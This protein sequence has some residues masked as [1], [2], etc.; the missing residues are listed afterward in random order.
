LFSILKIR[1]EA[2]LKPAVEIDEMRVGI[3]QERSLGQEPERDGQASGEGLDEP[4]FGVRQPEWPQV[5]YLPSFSA[6]PLQG[7]SERG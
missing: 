6:R 5:W 2:L 1:L 3:I 4:H 7:R